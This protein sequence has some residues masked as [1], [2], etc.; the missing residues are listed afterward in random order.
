MDI[1]QMHLRYDAPADRILWQVRTRGGELLSVWLT[2]RLL[3]MIWAPFVDLVG[4]AQ[5][6]PTTSTLAAAGTPPPLLVP[7]ARA[8]MAEVART[9]ELPGADFSQP[10]DRSMPASEPLGAEPLLPQTVDLGPR[11]EGGG[12]AI[13]LRDG[14]G[15]ALAL[16]LD[17][18]LSSA[19][20]RLLEQALRQADW[21]LPVAPAAPVAAADAPHGAVWLN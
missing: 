3:S 18:D 5:L 6:A 15:R 16:Q 14:G 10:F 13:R 4:R 21:G 20:L 8:L 9:R 19:L 11:P 7:E 2:R 17:P 1:H 12:L